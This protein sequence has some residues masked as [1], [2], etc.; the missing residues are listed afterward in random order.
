MTTGASIAEVVGLLT[1]SMS[2]DKVIRETAEKILLETAEKQPSALVP[3]LLETLKCR[4][5]T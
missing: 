2:P 3:L 4:F 1:N 5:F